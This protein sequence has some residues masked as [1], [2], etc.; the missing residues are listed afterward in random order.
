MYSNGLDLGYDYQAN[1]DVVA[2][3]NS[4]TGAHD[5]V[6]A[7][8]IEQTL[9]NGESSYKS[10]YWPHRA[11]QSDLWFNVGQVLDTH[12]GAAQTAGYKS[13]IS[14]R[15]NGEAT[16]RL[17]SDPATGAVA[18]NEFSDANG[19]YAVATEQAAVTAA[20]V[21]FFHLPL[22]S[23][24]TSTWTAEQFELY[25][26]VLKQAE[27]LGPVL[28]HCASGYRSAAYVLAYLTSKSGRC[29][30]WA[31]QQSAL[32]GVVYDSAAQSSTDKQVVAFFQEVL[33]C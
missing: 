33:K 29:T 2:F 10:Y 15:D 14:F 31:L 17:A 19:N 23:G 7:E 32:I 30:E 3:V 1:A 21:A 12:I 8:I 24:G 4:V 5:T 28:A 6:H 20:G 13:V 9:A 26:P 27:A 16:N 11:G 25:L 18:N 22:T